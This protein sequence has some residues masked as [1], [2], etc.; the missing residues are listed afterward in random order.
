M[1]HVHLAQLY[2]RMGYPEAAAAQANA[3]RIASARML[4]QIY[5][6]LTA[7][8]QAIDADQLDAVARYLPEIEDLL[9][10]GI[11]CGAW[12]IPGTSSASAATSACSPRSKTRS[13]ISASTI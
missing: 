2:A 1:Q 13:T 3:V 9:Q 11:E 4:C 8:H 12:S 10:R 7:G 5:C 6:R